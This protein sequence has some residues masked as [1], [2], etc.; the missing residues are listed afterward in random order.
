MGTD[1]GKSGSLLTYLYDGTLE[2]LFSCVFRAYDQKEEPGAFITRIEDTPLFAEVIS[3]ETHLPEALRVMEGIKKKIS[4]GFFRE[5]CLVFFGGLPG[6]E[7]LLWQS[8]VDAF[9]RGRGYDT[10]LQDPLRLQIQ[11]TALKVSREVHRFKGLIRFRKLKTGVYYAPFHPTHPI[12]ML[13]M[14]FF[15]GRFADQSL[16]LHDVKRGEVGYAQD[17]EWEFLD[18][19]REKVEIGEQLKSE[20]LDGDEES[21]QQL[22]QTFFDSIAIRERKNPRLQRQFMPKKYWEYLVEK[23]G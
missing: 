12:L 20:N 6:R 21:F 17:G 19:G 10:L 23:P 14:P 18:L 1:G 11:Q 15:A 13:L 22:W 8:I 16:V 7:L 3:I 9:K 5:L 4:P 2:G